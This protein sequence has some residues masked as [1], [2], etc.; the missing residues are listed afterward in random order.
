M[1]AVPVPGT[2]RRRRRD[3]EEVALQKREGRRDGEAAA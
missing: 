2:R 3:Q 1:V